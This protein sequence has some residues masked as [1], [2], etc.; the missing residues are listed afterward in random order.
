M[1]TPHRSRRKQS[2]SGIALLIAIFA[3]MLIN[4]VAITLIGASGSESSLAGNY[5]SSTSAYYAGFAGLE[6]GRGRV[7]PSNPNY[8]DPM[9]GAQL[10]A[11]GTLRYIVNPA[12]GESAATI[13]TSYPDTEYDREFGAGSYATE[14][15][16]ASGRERGETRE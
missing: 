1:K 7:L 3:L 12:P 9:A 8:F 4:V 15:R 16:R 13:L 2:E 11:V 14:I 5:R 6:E 10:L